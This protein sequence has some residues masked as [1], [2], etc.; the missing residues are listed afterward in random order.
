MFLEMLIAIKEVS[1]GGLN[2]L[3]KKSRQSIYR[4]PFQHFRQYVYP[5]RHH[6]GTTHARGK[7]FHHSRNNLDNVNA[8][9]SQI[10]LTH[11]RIEIPDWM[12][13]Q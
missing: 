12:S 4:L 3:K 1:V 13:I 5:H 7:A 8:V 10:E 6:Y 9:R 2:K 11:C